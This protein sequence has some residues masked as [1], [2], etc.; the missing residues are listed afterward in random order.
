M[1]NTTT[2][3]TDSNYYYKLCYKYDDKEV[4]MTFSADTTIDKARTN[5]KHF[6]KACSWTESQA[7]LIIPKDEE[8]Y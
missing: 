7:E 2:T 8:E 4:E 6:L 3:V 5:I 1:V